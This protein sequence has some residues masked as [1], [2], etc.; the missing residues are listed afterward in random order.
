MR[1][2]EIRI[3][4]FKSIVD[5][6][7]ILGRLNCFIG[8]N[9]AGKSNFLEAVGVLGAASSGRVDDEA[10][11]R[12]GVR[13]GLPRLFKN[14]FAG[15]AI[16]PHITVQADGE[17]VATFRVSLL[18]PLDTHIDSGVEPRTTGFHR[19]QRGVVG[20]QRDARHDQT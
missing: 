11:F 9:G 16:P 2:R 14:S 8:A 10:I 3:K 1:L 18:N 4:G 17:P 20:R 13:A 19:A 5:Q 12:R 15:M 7:L 6:T